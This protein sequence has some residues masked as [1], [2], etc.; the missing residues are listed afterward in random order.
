MPYSETE[1]ITT[2][3]VM[4]AIRSKN[5]D[6]ARDSV[7]DLLYNKSAEAMADKKVEIAKSIG[8]DKDADAAEP[9]PGFDA[10]A[11]V[12]DAPVTADPIDYE[13]TTSEE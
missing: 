4:D 7:Q 1:P 8:K 10:T 9:I 13:T 3:D 2:K 5:L 11:D 6:R 12:I